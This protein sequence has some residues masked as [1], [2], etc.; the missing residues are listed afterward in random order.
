MG[1]HQALEP[2]LT[3]LAQAAG[4]DELSAMGLRFALVEA[5]N[6]IIEH[7][8][9][10]ERGKPIDLSGTQDV[11]NLTFVLRD[12]GLPMPLPLPDGSPAD[13]MSESGRGWQII[14]AAFPE[15]CYAR[16]DGESV[17]TLTRPLTGSAA[18]PCAGSNNA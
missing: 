2:Q 11:L 10:N 18:E 12:S 7:A 8:Y 5:V 14:R 13:P 3:A 9:A 1:W 6:N 16:I 4:L 15:V 17:L